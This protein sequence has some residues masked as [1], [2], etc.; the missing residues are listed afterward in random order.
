MT[1]V[2]LRIRLLKWSCLVDLGARRHQFCVYSHT[3]MAA[4]LFTWMRTYLPCIQYSGNPFKMLKYKQPWPRS[5]SPHLG[6]VDL[7]IF[8]KSCTI[9]L[10]LTLSLLGFVVLMNINDTWN[11]GGNWTVSR[12]LIRRV[13]A[14]GID[15]NTQP[16]CLDASP[17]LTLTISFSLSLSILF[18]LST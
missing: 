12:Q 1:A 2:N 7:I 4:I 6:L 11:L 9:S 15:Y 8:R 16:W 17:S 13:F 18:T 3:Y 14:V 5:W 10:I